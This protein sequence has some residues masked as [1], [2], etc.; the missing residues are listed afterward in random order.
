MVKK[1][2]CDLDC[3]LARYEKFNDPN[4]IGEMESYLVDGVLEGADAPAHVLRD[5]PVQGTEQD[6]VAQLL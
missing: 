2:K 3:D 1:D 5:D 4:N 6:Y